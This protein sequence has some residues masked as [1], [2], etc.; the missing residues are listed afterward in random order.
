[1]IMCVSVGTGVNGLMLS[2]MLLV[3]SHLPH[4]LLLLLALL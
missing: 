4:L 2:A 1:M 3:G